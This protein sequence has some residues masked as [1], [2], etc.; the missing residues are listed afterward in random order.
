[1]GGASDPAN[2]AR[3]ILGVG[4][5]TP[6]AAPARCVK[7]GPGR[8][9]VLKRAE[10]DLRQLAPARAPRPPTPNPFSGACRLGR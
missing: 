3:S 5:W 10:F 8:N 2:P 9:T 6:P 7:K 4:T 1:M